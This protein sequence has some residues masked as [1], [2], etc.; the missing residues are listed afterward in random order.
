M[1]RRIVRASKSSISA[2]TDE[3]R[4]QVFKEKMD[5]IEDDFSFVQAGLEKLFR[6]GGQ[7]AESATAL[8]AEL[9]ESLQRCISEMAGEL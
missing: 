2:A 6:N 4:E 3:A 8:A 7:Q 5:A 9:S 1:K